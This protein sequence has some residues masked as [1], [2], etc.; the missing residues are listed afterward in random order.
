MRIVPGAPHTVTVQ[1]A[2]D[3]IPGD[4]ASSTAIT[5]TVIDTNGYPVA[6]GAEVAFSTDYGALSQAKASTANGIAHVTLTSVVSGPV[7]ATVTASAGEAKG[8]VSIAFLWPDLIVAEARAQQP[9]AQPGDLVQFAFVYGNAG[10]AIASDVVVSA[11]L[12]EGLTPVRFNTLGLTPQ[13]TGDKPYQW[14]APVVDAEAGGWLTVTA[15]VDPAHNWTNGHV[16]TVP[17]GIEGSEDF[18]ADNNHASV[19]WRVE[20]LTLHPIGDQTVREG[21][22]LTF[23]VSASGPDGAPPT[24]TATSL[25]T[26]ATFLNNTFTWTPSYEDA[27]VYTVTFTAASSDL[28]DTETIHITVD[29]LNRPP[30]LA[31][32]GN[33]NVREGETLTFTV[34]ASDPDGIT[35][36]LTASPLP[37]GATFLNDTFTWTPDAGDAG[38]YTVT[39]NASD[40]YLTDTETIHITVHDVDSPPQRDTIYLPLVLRTYPPRSQ[41]LIEDAVP[42][43]GARLVTEQGETF[44]TATLSLAGEVPSDGHF[45]FSRDPHQVLPVMVDD[46]LALVQEGQDIFTYTFSSEGVSPAPAIVEVPRE[47]VQAIAGGGV[48]IEYRDVYGDVIQA[49]EVWLIW[50]P[51]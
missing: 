18:S 20:L 35:P 16:V 43:V 51:R 25:P 23:T 30:V 49:T 27:G 26:G 21:E 3:A 37:T 47:V 2:Q 9:T 1:S 33:K 22:T 12:P 29:D 31:P 48:S 4:G 44:Y 40:S 41:P 46:Q 17:I 39:F 28:T 14:A 24:I 7:T 36:T 34:S 6:D 45:Y 15:E 38:I 32:I 11:R 5:A 13:Q 10:N 19:Q 50:S 42:Q 8:Q